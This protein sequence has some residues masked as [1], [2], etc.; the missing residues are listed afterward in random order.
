MMDRNEAEN[1]IKNTIEYA[2]REIKKSKIRYRLIIAAIAF[3]I[4]GFILF[5]ALKPISV[6]ISDSDI[7]TEEDINKAV[8]CV[9]VDFASLQGCKLFSLSYNGDTHS[10][11]E[12]E[13]QLKQG[14]EYDEYIVIDSVFLSPIFGGGAWNACRIYSWSWILGRYVDGEWVVIDRGV[15]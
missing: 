6:N 8:E 4:L 3:V 15:C 14:S 12:K 10:L 2:N 13:Y 1:V 9:K 11:R 7:F 5:M